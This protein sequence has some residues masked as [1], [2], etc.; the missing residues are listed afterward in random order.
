MAAN[1]SL[2][3]L[4]DRYLERALPTG[5][6]RAR[7]VRLTQ[8]GEMFRRPGA[9]PMR[10]TAVERFAVDRVAFAW[11]ARF[12]I[13]P[14]VSLRVLDTYAHGNGMLK[15]RLL[16]LPLQNQS[17]PSMSLAEAYRYLAEL[18]WMPQA[19]ASNAE[20]DWRLVDERAV[21]VMTVAR[22]QRPTVRIEFDEN[23][24]IARC[25]ARARPREV[26]GGSVLTRWGG[27]LGEYRTLGGMRMPIRGE[28]FWDP[29][30]GRFVYWR[31]EVTSAEALAEPF[32]ED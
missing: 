21:D 3:A 31:G 30:E 7:Q 22:D 5:T 29:P 2:P 16:G 14:L 6:V 13:V 24:D 10:F 26:N 17:G 27:Q 15:V 4:V 8:T 18:P 32:E 20:L 11:E 9:R 28:V 25:S 12:R 23:G 19:M 1:G